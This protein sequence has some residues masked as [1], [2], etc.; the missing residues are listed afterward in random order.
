MS[1]G[2]E[3]EMVGAGGAVSF[4]GGTGLA[5]Y[6]YFQLFIVSAVLVLCMELGA[7]RCTARSRHDRRHPLP[8]K[9]LP[10]GF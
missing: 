10:P 8:D 3:S 6:G 5:W 4:G 9:R 1:L 7:A 2:T